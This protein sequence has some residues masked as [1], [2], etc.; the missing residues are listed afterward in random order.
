MYFAHDEPRPAPF[1]ADDLT[2]EHAKEFGAYLNEV[3]RGLSERHPEGSVEERAARTLKEAIGIHLHAL[4]ECFD[5]EEPETLQARKAAWTPT[6]TRRSRP[7]AACSRRGRRPQR[8]MRHPASSSEYG[9]ATCPCGQGL[10]PLSGVLSSGDVTS[11][12]LKRPHCVGPVLQ[13]A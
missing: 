5:D 10:L 7:P 3:T 4:N 12:F 13:S 1:N 6:P 8:S 2:A 9:C 11:G